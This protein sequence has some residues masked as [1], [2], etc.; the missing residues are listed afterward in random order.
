MSAP[1]KPE[2]KYKKMGISPEFEVAQKLEAY[3]IRKFKGN[4]SAAANYLLGALVR[5]RYR[6]PAALRNCSIEAIATVV[7]AIKT[8]LFQPFL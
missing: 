6:T 8:Y 2:S 1:Q 3:A 4:K 5:A 7:W